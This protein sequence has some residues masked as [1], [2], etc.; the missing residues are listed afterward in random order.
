M[1]QKKNYAFQYT[2]LFSLSWLCLYFIF[3]AWISSH[4]SFSS[5]GLSISGPFARTLVISGFTIYFSVSALL[6][7]RYFNALTVDKPVIIRNNDWFE[8]IRGNL[9][10]F[11]VCCLSL[12]LHVR[13]FSFIELGY[14]T[15][16]LWL[17]DFSNKYW[18]GLF[19]FPVQYGFWS[20][21]MVLLVLLIKK[22]RT[23]DSIADYVHAKLVV[24]RSENPAKLLLILGLF[25]IF[26]LYSYLFPYSWDDSVKLLREPPVSHYLYLVTYYLFGVSQMGP[27]IVQL[28]FYILGAV[29][30]Y[31]TVLLFREKETALLGATIYLFSPVI[32][33]YA[34]LTFLSS[35]AVFFMILISF[36][37]LRFIK[38]DDNRDLI[39]TSYFIG[40]GFMYRREILVMFIVCFAYLALSK[41]KRRDRHSF[42][43]F[44]ILLLSLITIVPFYLIG[45]GGVNYYA[46]EVSN[47]LAI[48][49][50]FMV[51]Q[52]QLSV[53][54]SYLLLVSLCFVLFKRD[55]LSLF[56][57]LYFIAY[58]SFFTLSL[59]PAIQR[60]SMAVYPAIAVFIAQFVFNITNKIRGKHIFKLSYAILGAYLIFLCLAPR[61]GTDL[62]TFKYKDFET[63]RY[64][65]EKATEW[66]RDKTNN[67]EKILAFMP[68]YYKFYL[69]RIFQDRDII[70]Q[71]RFIYYIL[72]T[73]KE[74]IGHVEDLNYFYS[75]NIS[76]IM[77]PYGP[78][79]DYPDIGSSK[80]TKYLKEKMDD[81][82]TEVARFNH[83][84]NYILIYKLKGN[85][86]G[87]KEK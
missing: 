28:I 4:S 74:L 66:I 52:S 10:L 14:I 73:A 34:T 67:N 53:M 37:F 82:F 69:E 86:A 49:S 47:L 44:K 61:S 45:R 54:L 13:E 27:R 38:E 75:E 39:L 40:L 24:Y 20:L 70:N 51:L 29:Y 59:A 16:G 11:I 6:I 48:D 57:G 32:F 81:G 26:S 23:I 35:G 5:K 63:Q 17:Y 58:Y 22:R 77:F 19:G 7:S 62:V 9:W 46:P 25:S 43:H 3:P 41:I 64:P 2:V 60:Y 78:R 71:Q 42:I 12:I 76:Y 56:Y 68:T 30:L 83:D 21:I 55:D 36:H 15:Q 80:E 72:G 18:H 79:N 85:N 8:N 87:L 84:D 33:H 1:V 50:I 31:R 65:V